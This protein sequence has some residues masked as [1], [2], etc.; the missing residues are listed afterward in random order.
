LIKALRRSRLA[1]YALRLA[2][3]GATAA[4]TLG[5][6]IGHNQRSGAHRNEQCEKNFFHDFSCFI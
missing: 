5:F 3:K 6:G 2:T 1:T 4:E